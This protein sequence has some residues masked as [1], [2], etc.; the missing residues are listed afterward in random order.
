MDK[1]NVYAVFG[2]TDSKVIDDAIARAY[3]EDSYMIAPGQWLIRDNTVQPAEVYK[4]LMLG[5]EHTR[6]VVTRMFGYYGWH[7]K[8]IWDWIEAS[9]RGE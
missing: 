2:N 6:C 3:A 7:D 8:A 4:K 5:E 1:N 9:S